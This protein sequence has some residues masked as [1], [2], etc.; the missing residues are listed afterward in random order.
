MML[1]FAW[2]QGLVPVSDAALHRAMALNRVAPEANVRA[3]ALGRVMAVTPEH[4]EDPVTGRRCP[5]R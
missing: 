4:L 3:F 5:R 2:Q 1:G